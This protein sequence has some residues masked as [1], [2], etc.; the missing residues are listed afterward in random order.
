MKPHLDLT[1]ENKPLVLK[2]IEG[3]L[4]LQTGVNEIEAKAIV[5]EIRK[6]VD[7]EKDSEKATT[8]GVVCPFRA[9]VKYIQKLIDASFS[10]NEVKK[11]NIN[12]G[13][14][15]TYQGDERDIIMFSMNLSEGYFRQ[16]VTFAQN[17]N[18]LNVAVTRS[19]KKMI[20]FSSIKPEQLPKGL[21]RD[22]LEYCKDT[23]NQQ[24]GD[25]K[26]LEEKPMLKEVVKIAKAN[27]IQ[28][29]PGYYTAGIKTDCL[30]T[31]GKKHAIL[32]IDEYIEDIEQ[33]IAEQET[34]ER[35]GWTVERVN[36]RLLQKGY[37]FMKELL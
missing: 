19:K 14:A 8:M 12:V 5:D 1:G 25:V 11:H 36:A 26:I 13:T 29:Y 18:L 33:S 16:S 23:Q 28:A 22:Y 2:E 10:G 24:I 7:S 6:I 27:Y 31:N 35:L 3:K 21:L 17:P 30:L 20:V 32:I 15:H 4:D 9:Q 34:L 37:N